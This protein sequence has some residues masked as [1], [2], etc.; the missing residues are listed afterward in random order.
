MLPSFLHTGRMR[1]SN[2]SH[3]FWV[4]NT[5]SARIF[6]VGKPCLLTF[7][8]DPNKRMLV[9]IST[10]KATTI[11]VRRKVSRYPYA[12]YKMVRMEMY[13]IKPTFK[14]RGSFTV[15]CRGEFT[16]TPPV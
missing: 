10:A 2:K 1:Y 12:M 4:P 3:I 9:Q 5:Q 14:P 15:K 8:L 6:T 13:A 11:I 7:Q 16:R